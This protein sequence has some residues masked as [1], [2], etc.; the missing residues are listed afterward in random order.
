[1]RFLPKNEVSY[2]YVENCSWQELLGCRLEGRNGWALDCMLFRDGWLSREFGV[3]L[4]DVLRI[5][6]DLEYLNV[7]EGFVVAEPQASELLRAL[8]LVRSVAERKEKRG[9]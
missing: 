3:G 2:D 7:D 6:E 4:D 9:G 1:M 5:F 8:E